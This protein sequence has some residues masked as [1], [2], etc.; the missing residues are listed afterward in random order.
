MLSF[1]KFTVQPQPVMLGYPQAEN[2]D[3]KKK[4]ESND[5]MIITFKL[6]I[7]KTMILRSVCALQI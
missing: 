4:I 7:H 1:V 3:T 2:R 6:F 5:N